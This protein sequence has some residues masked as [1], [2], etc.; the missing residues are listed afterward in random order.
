[1]R[2]RADG[3]YLPDLNGAIT[4]EDGVLALVHL[5]GYGQ[6]YAQPTEH[7]LGAVT[8]ATDDDR[9]AWLNGVLGAVAGEVH[10][11]REIVLDVAGRP[12]AA[13]ATITA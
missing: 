5:T 8:H 13:E 2:R 11:G 4:T 7:V 3:S 10:G 6:P 12:G 9:Y 1:M